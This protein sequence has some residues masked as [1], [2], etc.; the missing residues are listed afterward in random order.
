MLKSA[1]TTETVHSR[2]PLE[3]VYLVA[4]RQGTRNEGVALTAYR[5]D[6][7]GKVILQKRIPT[8]G[9]IHLQAISFVRQ[10]QGVQ[11][12]LHGAS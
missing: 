4:S 2:L 8:D 1:E 5:V 11:L 12:R 10:K 3:I 9:I 7:T 6:R